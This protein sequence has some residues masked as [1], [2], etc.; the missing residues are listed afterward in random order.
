MNQQN[1]FFNFS[2]FCIKAGGKL[3]EI[4]SSEQTKNI[5]QFLSKKDPNNK[6]FYWIGLT[7]QK[8]EGK[9]VWT[10]TGKEAWYTNWH[11]D[12]PNVEK[13]NDEDCV[14]LQKG[15]RTWEDFSCSGVEIFALCEKGQ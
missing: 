6:N 11:E 8:T 12:E 9:F 14:F 13:T 7:D 15:D 1:I 2:Q 10:S 4:T 5:N 3:A